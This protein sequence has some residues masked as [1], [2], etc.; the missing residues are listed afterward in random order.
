MRTSVLAALSALLLLP[1]CWSQWDNGEQEDT[2][3]NQPPPMG[4]DDDTPPEDT[5]EDGIPDD[6]EGEEDPDGDGIPNDEDTDSDGDGIPDSVE[7]NGDSDGDGIPDYLDLDSDGDG[8]PDSV[9]GSGDTDGDGIPDYLDDDSDG[10]GI[11]DSQEGWDDIDGDGIPNFQDTD[12]D[13][14]GIPDGE[15]DDYDGDGIP[16]DVEGDVD[17][18]G[19][20]IPDWLDPDSD[21]DGIP[22][23]EETE[24]D[25][26]NPDTDGDGWTDLQEQL[27]GSDPNDPL[28]FCQGQ[29]I[30]IPAYATSSV[31]VT[32]DTQVQ[33]GDVMFI[34]D[35]TGSMQGTLDDMADR[36]IEVVD[37]IS[38]VIPDLTFGVA[39]YDDYN[40]GDMGS[41]DDKPFKRRQQQTDDI[42][43]VQNAL[44]ALAA[45]GGDDWPESTLEALYQAATGFGY[46]QNCN[47]SFDAST[48]VRPFNTLPVDAFGGG[49]PGEYNA[50]VSGT[51]NLGGNGFRQGAVPILVYATDADVRNAFPPYNQGPHGTGIPDCALDAATP[52]LTDALDAIDA[53]TIGVPAGTTDAQAAMEVIAE[54]TDSWFDTNGNGVPDPGEHMVYP[55]ASYDVVDQVVNGITEFTSNV[56]YDLTMEATDPDGAIVDVDP[57]VYVN[58]PA[59]NTVTFTLTLEPTPD[60]LASMFSDTVYVVPTTLY[61]DGSVILAQWDLVFVVSVTP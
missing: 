7:G 6:V 43:A 52:F 37:D 35:E 1:A 36:F 49:T 4:D 16:N 17:S 18:D 54:A 2:G 19:D 31:T 11:P 28:D 27:C 57:P 39:S 21:N 46:D 20:G 47:G 8:I 51:G 61:G 40:F 45:G 26:T 59:L 14:D 50:S 42:N 30:P 15:D 24:T 55:S 9:E 60:E 12:S 34:L 25:P 56:T 32:Y 10:D 33:L 53:R 41:G 5:D 58:V 29:S 44:G 3:L 38:L 22:D 13:G 23:A 48:D